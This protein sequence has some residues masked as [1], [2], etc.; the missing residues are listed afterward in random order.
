[1]RRPERYGGAGGCG[2]PGCRP[3][4]PG[5]LPA[6]GPAL[7]RSWRCH[8]PEGGSGS[9][10]YP[11]GT[12]PRQR[13]W[14]RYAIEH[15]P[16]SA[17]PPTIVSQRRCGFFVEDLANGPHDTSEP[18]TAAHDAP[19]GTLAARQGAGGLRGSRSQPAPASCDAA[20][21]ESPPAPGVQRGAAGVVSRVRARR[22]RA[23]WRPLTR[24]RRRAAM[25]RGGT[26]I[27]ES[28]KMS[29]VLVGKASGRVGP[30][31]GAS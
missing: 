20:D 9:D 5:G 28:T 30:P 6:G 25:H 2:L 24:P 1:M 16:P 29:G 27:G 17:A 4:R 3:T 7:V 10:R 18:T 22:S 19:G 12:R 26:R 15:G 13:A 21:G 11:S 14:S 23:P 8:R 31:R